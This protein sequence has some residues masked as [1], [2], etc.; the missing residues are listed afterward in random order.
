VL[1][2]NVTSAARIIWFGETKFTLLQRKGDL[3]GKAVIDQFQH[4]L[5]SD[6]RRKMIALLLHIRDVSDSVL[7][8]DIRCSNI[9]FWGL[10]SQFGRKAK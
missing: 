7:G 9:I 8:C 1:L 3:L 4:E 2:L 5:S 6:V 10:L